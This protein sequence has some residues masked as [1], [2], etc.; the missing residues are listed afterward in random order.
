VKASGTS[1]GAFTSGSWLTRT[2]NNID[3]P[4][5]L[6]VSLA[7]SQFILPAGIYDIEVNAPAY[8]VARH[9]A[10]LRN[11]TDSVDLLIGGSD[12]NAQA[13]PVQ[14]SSVI[15]GRINITS[16][17]TFEIQHRATVTKT[18]DGFGVET[19]VGV[20]EVY[21]QVKIVKVEE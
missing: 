7:S 2:L 8:N 11:I 21:T 5:G 20:D 14:T 3:D 16:Q 10:K 18:V 12:Y 4:T 1:G 9:K 13:A 17:K 19:L 6:V 15:T